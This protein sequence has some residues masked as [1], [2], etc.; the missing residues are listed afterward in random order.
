ME[1]LFSG[2]EFFDMWYFWQFCDSVS[3]IFVYK[4]APFL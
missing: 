3:V 2:V 4:K 1:A